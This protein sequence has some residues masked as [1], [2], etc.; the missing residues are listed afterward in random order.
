MYLYGYLALCL[1]IREMN[2][3]MNDNTEF[4]EKV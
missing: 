3:V 1:S 2:E 4:C